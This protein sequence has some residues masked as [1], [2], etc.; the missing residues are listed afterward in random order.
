METTDILELKVYVVVIVKR[1]VGLFSKSTSTIYI[2]NIKI[3]IKYQL[4]QTDITRN[5]QL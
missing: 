4:I 3:N 1:L 2:S 5:I